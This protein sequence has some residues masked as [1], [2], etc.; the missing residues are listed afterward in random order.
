[1]IQSRF[2]GALALVGS[3]A[4]FGLSTGCSS[5]S[6]SG[7]SGTTDSGGGGG[8]DTGGGGGDTGGGS[9]NGTP[10]THDVQV[11]GTSFTFTPS[12]LSICKGDTVHWVWMGG[13]HT[14]TSGTVTGGAG[15]ADNNFCNQ[16]DTNCSANPTENAGNT[17]DHTFATSGA[18]PYFCRP[19]A[20]SGMT[21]TIT[22]Q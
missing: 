21:G 15:T 5:T 7:P 16:N 11:G 8:G 6:T 19:H 22:V 13:P 9:C 14:V 18:F 4:S 3:I 1:M 10:A 17:Y 2:L 20:G 12:A